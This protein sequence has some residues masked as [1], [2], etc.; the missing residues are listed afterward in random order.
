VSDKQSAHWLY[1]HPL[2]TFAAVETAKLDY[3]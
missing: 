1:L 2:D 3:W